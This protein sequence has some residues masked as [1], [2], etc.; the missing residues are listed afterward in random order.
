[1]VRICAPV[2]RMVFHVAACGECR[3]VGCYNDRG[4]VRQ[5]VEDSDHMNLLETFN[6]HIVTGLI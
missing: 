2:V 3:G 6:G 1:M 5:Y 4:E